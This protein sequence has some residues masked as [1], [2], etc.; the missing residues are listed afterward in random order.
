TWTA[1]QTYWYRSIFEEFF[2]TPAAARTVP[3]GPSI[4]CST[5]RAIEWDE[6]FKVRQF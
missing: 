1:Y 2:P 4:A 5:A 6:S 3:G